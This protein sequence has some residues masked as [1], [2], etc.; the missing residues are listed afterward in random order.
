[1]GG[2]LEHGFTELI[3]HTIRKNYYTKEARRCDITVTSC[4]WSWLLSGRGVEVP[5]AK[6]R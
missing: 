3:S 2:L 1:M 6:N 4:K 5:E